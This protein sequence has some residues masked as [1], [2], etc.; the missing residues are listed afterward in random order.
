MVALFATPFDT[1]KA[2]IGNLFTPQSKF[3][4]P[5]ELSNRNGQKKIFL[6]KLEGQFVN[7]RSTNFCAEGVKRSFMNGTTIFCI[8]SRLF[9]RGYVPSK[10]RLLQY[11]GFT[12]LTQSVVYYLGCLFEL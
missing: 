2:K 6:R 1:F 9:E 11:F 4:C 5:V 8:K 7:E 12:I 3:E 10:I